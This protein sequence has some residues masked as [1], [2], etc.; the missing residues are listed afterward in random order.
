MRSWTRWQ[1]WAAVVIGV[2]AI[3]SF[4]WTPTVTAATLSLIVLGALLVINALWSL[5]LPGAIAS[6]YVHSVL[7]VL[8]FISPWVM[9]FV[10]STMA[11]AW[12][13][14]V[15]GILALASGIWAIPYST[16][17]HHNKAAVPQA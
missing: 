8:L 13:G 16:R 5:A 4:I 7:G 14:W 17:A 1:D 11:M 6:E 12:T 15:T 2:Y 9:G 3:L 10:S